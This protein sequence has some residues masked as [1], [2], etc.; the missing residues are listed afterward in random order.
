MKENLLIIALFLLSFTVKAPEGLQY[1]ILLELL[2]LHPYNIQDPLLLSFVKVE[3]DFKE[4]AVNEVS[5]A[6]GILQILPCMID[7]VNRILKLNKYTWDDAFNA[8][9]SMEIWYIIQQYHNPEYDIEKAC[10]IWFGKGVQYDGCT[11]EDYQRK[12]MNNG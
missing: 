8:F 4:D 6:R 1:F 2:P 12:V 11:W 9:K 10:K 5:G 3:S 7:E